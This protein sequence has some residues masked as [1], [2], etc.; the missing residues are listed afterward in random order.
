MSV[1]PRPMASH[2]AKRYKWHAAWTL[3]VA[4][5][6]ARHASGLVYDFHPGWRGHLQPPMGDK[7]PCGCWHGV[8]RGG[9]EIL[10]EVEHQ[11][12]T[13]LCLEACMLFSTAASAACQDC[14]KLTLGD[15]YYMVNDALWEAAH[16]NG[17]GKLCLACLQRRMGRCLQYSDFT[18]VPVNRHNSWVQ[19]LRTWPARPG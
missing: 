9:A 12:L 5:R 1:S 2:G 11:R 7:C 15:D 17:R 8:L 14:T 18:D 13:R 3:D 6:E 10:G 19:A 16:P 4:A